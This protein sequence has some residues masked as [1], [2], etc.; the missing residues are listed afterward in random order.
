MP[1]PKKKTTV[2]PNQSNIVVKNKPGVIE[3]GKYV[4]KK[5]TIKDSKAQRPPKPGPK[6]EEEKKPAKKSTDK[7]KAKPEQKSKE[8]LEK[9]KPKQTNQKSP[10]RGSEKDVSNSP[11]NRKP[12]DDFKAKREEQN[13]RQ[14]IG[15]KKEITLVTM[16]TN[17]SGVLGLTPKYKIQI[18]K[19]YLKFKPDVIFIQDSFDTA[20]TLEVMKEVSGG[21]FQS[22]FQNGLSSEHEE[23]YKYY[24]MEDEKDE[25]GK[26][27]KAAQKPSPLTG[28]VWDKTKYEATPLQLEDE[29][30]GSVVRWIK[31]HN[32]TI[33]K[34]DSIKKGAD[35]VYPTFIAISWHGPDYETP[36]RQRAKQCEEFFEFVHD[37]RYNNHNIPV[38]IGGDFNMDMKSYDLKDFPQLLLVPY[39]PMSGKLAKDLKNTFICTM[40]CMQVIET[41][42][43]EHHPEVFQAP[44][45]TIKMR[46]RQ[47]VK[48]W[49]VLKIQRFW[50]QKLVD[51]RLKEQQQKMININQKRWKKKIGGEDYIP[52]EESEPEPALPTYT[53]PPAPNISAFENA[54]PSMEWTQNNFRRRKFDDLKS[55]EDRKREASFNQQI[56]RDI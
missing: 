25:E 52:D 38:V 3:N 49:A 5:V 6:K 42:Y 29:R 13:L 14:L 31:M 7:V 15:S 22:F 27:R 54:Q 32:I 8:T 39:R 36:L 18:V 46:S 56:M 53:L 11:R 48:I 23:P 35:D 45:V 28:I 26:T 37:L 2:R 19:E 10:G 43:K 24:S 1:A 50:R 47:R 20:D 51:R 55:V 16:N 33:V 12:R 30:L 21:N 9:P 34:L 4:A 17:G 41:S 44:F 40:D